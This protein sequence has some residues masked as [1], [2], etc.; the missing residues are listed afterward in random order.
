[1]KI[2]AGLGNPGEKY[3]NTRHNVGFMVT[4]AL[5]SKYNVKGSFNSKFNA[6][7]GKGV[8]KDIEVL[9]VQPL[10]YMNLSGE[11]ISKIMN[12]YKV[13]IA[14]LFVV[15]DDVSLDMGKIRFREEGSAGGHNGIKSIISCCC[16]QNFPRLKVGIG[17]NPGEHLC[18]SYVLEKF[19]AEESEILKKIIPL[20]V[21]A[22]EDYLLSGM[23]FAQNKYNGIDV[24]ESA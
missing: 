13:D 19:T 6:I 17:P 21:E 2:I 16:G 10:T 14:D 7:V 23:N 3:K 12:W 5:A 1:M 8:V 4:E 18:T 9:I 24:I 20:S 11:A 22:V 15:F